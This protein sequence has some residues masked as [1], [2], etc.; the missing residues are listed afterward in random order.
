VGE[1]SPDTHIIFNGDFVDRGAW[2]IETLAL[3]AAWRLA[4]PQHVTLL[5]GNHESATCT[6]VY[7]FH[8]ELAAKYG[9]AEGGAVYRAARTA[10]SRLPLAAA[11]AAGGVPGCGALVLHGGLFRAPLPRGG[12]PKRPRAGGRAARA[13]RA[14][15]PALGTLAQLRLASKGGTDPSGR[16]AS[17]LAAD[18]LWSDPAP[19]GGV[20]DNH[21]RGVGLLFGPDATQAFC[22][23]NGVAC[24]LRSHE[25]PDARDGRDGMS[26]ILGGWALDHAGAAGSLYT[27][28]SA[29][30]YPMFVPEGESRFN[31]LG[32]VAVLTAP[33]WARPNFIQYPAA[34]RPPASPFYALADAP[35]SDEDVPT[36][37]GDGGGSDL[38]SAGGGGSSGES[39]GEEA[40]AAPAARGSPRAAAA[41]SAGA[42]PRTAP[43]SPRA[44]LARAASPRAAPVRPASPRASPA[45]LAS[46]RA[47]AA[48]AASPRGV[49]ASA[50]AP[51]PATLA[52][53]SPRATRAHPEPDE[54][55]PL[56]PP[57]SP[58]P[59]PR[60]P[61]RAPGSPR[62]LASPRGV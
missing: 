47:A 15:P 28:F 55:A 56:A 45:R 35:D 59:A 18:V 9:G 43:A 60:S 12:A 7:G 30:D 11:V 38:S 39:E 31:N 42:S 53:T 54:G 32:A 14:T 27:V 57:P 8:G 41:R 46:P 16:G 26:G 36:G 6:L 25:G 22:A 33:S 13:A 37:F 3:L 21:A 49:G 2:G 5:R 19:S 62:R 24:V 58:K 1:P 23:A 34:P 50:P 44:A 40:V 29:A 4:A 61:A 51:A 48:R 17:R 10:F 52:P 20:A